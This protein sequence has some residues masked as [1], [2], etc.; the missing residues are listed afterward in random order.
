MKTYEKPKLM[1]LSISANDLLCRGCVTTTRGNS[2]FTGI[3]DKHG[4]NIF[5]ENDFPSLAPS[6]TTDGCEN[7][8]EAY[9]KFNGSNPIFTS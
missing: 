4:D 2:Y 1:V 3:F 9:C 6:F 8:Y 7:A 5:D